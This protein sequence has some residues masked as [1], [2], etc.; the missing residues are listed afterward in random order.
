MAYHMIYEATSKPDGIEKA[1]VPEGFGAC[2]ALILGS[3]IYP[4][5]GSLSL[6]MASLDGRTGAE[7]TDLEL[8][9]M[10]SLMAGHL[11]ESTT[12]SDPKRQVAALLFDMIRAALQAE[13]IKDVTITGK[14]TF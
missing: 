1:D 8:F 12:L 2:D 11:A 7:L 4:P 14:V 9:K 10:W 13:Q 6:Q 3:I 5:D